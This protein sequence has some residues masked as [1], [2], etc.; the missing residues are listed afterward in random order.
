M[1]TKTYE[2]TGTDVQVLRIKYLMVKCKPGENVEELLDKIIE[3]IERF[4]EDGD[5]TFTF[6]TEG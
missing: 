1:A 6:N 3:L 5:W 4:S 2:A